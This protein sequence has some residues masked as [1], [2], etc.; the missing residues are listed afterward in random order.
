M[1]LTAK[2]LVKFKNFLAF[3][4]K[5]LDN[6]TFTLSREALEQEITVKIVVSSNK[7]KKYPS[8]SL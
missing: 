4:Q 2:S 5:A 7:V 6:R 8:R 1:R 3:A